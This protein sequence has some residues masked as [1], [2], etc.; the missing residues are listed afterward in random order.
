MTITDDMKQ[1]AKL[2]KEHK[3]EINFNENGEISLFA[4]AGNVDV[5][6]G[7]IKVKNIMSAISA[8]E[9]FR[10]AGWVAN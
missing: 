10:D 8:L 2:A 4:E 7:E 1:V 9:A 3:T 5:T 6:I